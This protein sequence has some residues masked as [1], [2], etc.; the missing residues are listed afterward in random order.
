MVSLL[1]NNYNHC[2]MRQ[3]VIRYNRSPQGAPEMG[4]RI[5]ERT[6]KHTILNLNLCRL[7]RVMFFPD[8]QSP[9]LLPSSLAA[10]IGMRKL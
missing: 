4:E 8:F 9:S 10:S 6:T 7:R 2:C 1:Y 5:L 3:S